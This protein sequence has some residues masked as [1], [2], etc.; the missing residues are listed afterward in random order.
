MLEDL[1]FWVLSWCALAMLCGG[2]IKGVLGIGT[3]LLTV[4]MLTMVLPPQHAIAIMAVP[5]VVANVWQFREAEKPGDTLSRFWPAFLSIIAGTWVGVSILSRINEKLLLVI[6]GILVIGF[7]ILQGS[8]RRLTIP[9]RL[10]RIAG[11]GFCGASGVIGGLSSMFGPML[12]LYLVSLGNLGKSRFVGIISFLYIA[13]VVPWAIMLYAFGILDVPLLA[14]SSLAVIPT[15][16]GLAAGRV[17][18]SRIHETVFYRLV[19]LVLLVSGTSL[20]WRSI[21]FP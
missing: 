5:V 19:L 7:T 6:V 8:P 4:P 1:G 20:I 15:A 10:E 2:L 21:Q 3:P 13:A 12:V 18:R 16:A 9:A 17:I 11:I 14:A